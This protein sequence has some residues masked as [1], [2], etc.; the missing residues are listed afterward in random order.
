MM[1]S[2]HLL[3][4]NITIERPYKNQ[5]LNS[6]GIVILPSHYLPVLAHIKMQ[7]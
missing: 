6:I 1:K 7:F 4:N 3:E 5:K 2:F